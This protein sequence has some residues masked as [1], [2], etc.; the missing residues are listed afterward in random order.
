MHTH[1]NRHLRAINVNTRRVRPA[2]EPTEGERVIP[3]LTYLRADELHVDHGYQRPLQPTHI[4]GMVKTFDPLLFGVLVIAQ[5]T[6]G[7]Y[8][9]LDGQQRV[10]ALKR[11][12]KGDMLVPCE[13]MTGLSWGDEAR[14]YN[15]RNKNRKAQTPQQDFK[16]ALAW[17]SPTE[18]AI[19]R[20]VRASG[21]QLN[22]EQ[23]SLS[24]GRIVAV[25]DLRA[26]YTQRRDGTLIEVLDLIRATWGTNTGPHAQILVGLALF[27]GTYRERYKAKRFVTALGRVSPD[28]LLRE[29]RA[30]AAATKAKREY[31]G[32]AVI[33]RYYNDGLRAANK[34][35]S[36]DEMRA[37]NAA[38]EGA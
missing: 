21:F 24:D 28:Q 30:F 31:A 4:A 15:L 16:G 34:L 35:P 19:S 1:A 8:W 3:N 36:I 29:I 6:D 9:I 17:G 33:L 20:I 26:I 2:A 7:T 23:G 5:R 37:R 22:L 27:V 14:I 25:A 10:E 38:G 13:V 18:V 32:A 12:G 11:L